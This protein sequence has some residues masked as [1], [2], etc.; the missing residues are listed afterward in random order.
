M[1]GIL[2]CAKRIDLSTFWFPIFWQPL[3][4]IH[5]PKSNLL[6]LCP[7]RQPFLVVATQKGQPFIVGSFGRPSTTPKDPPPPPPPAQDGRTRKPPGTTRCFRPKAFR[8]SR[9]SWRLGFPKVPGRGSCMGLPCNHQRRICFKCFHGVHG[10]PCESF[11]KATISCWNL[12]TFWTSLWMGCVEGGF[13]GR[14]KST[15]GSARSLAM[16]TGGTSS[17]RDATKPCEPPRRMRRTHMFVPR[18][19]ARTP[20]YQKKFRHQRVLL[21]W[22]YLHFLG[23][24]AGSPF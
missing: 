15:H 12:G 20:I 2:S 8:R 22:E 24:P 9:N 5:L 11:S 21:G 4:V 19:G 17:H 14:S 1:R 16:S 7:F 10:L 18:S 3:L 23:P 6:T 13:G